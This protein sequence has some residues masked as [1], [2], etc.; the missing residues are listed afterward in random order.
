VG[1]EKFPTINRMLWM[2]CGKKKNSQQAID[3]CG[4]PWEKEKT[5]QA[6]DGCGWP[7]GKGKMP[8]KQ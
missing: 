5:Q 1:K 3:G 2:A 6:I 8:N 7:M 4:W